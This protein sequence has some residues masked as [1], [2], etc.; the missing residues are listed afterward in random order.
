MNLRPSR[1]HAIIIVSLLAHALRLTHIPAFR[2]APIIRVRLAITFTSHDSVALPTAIGRI[3]RSRQIDI[4]MAA[5]DRL[6]GAVPPLC[7]HEILRARK[8][9]PGHAWFD[10][11]W[12]VIGSFMS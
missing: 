4:D 12:T 10:V 7:K 1:A 5:L 2:A 11:A 8:T 9:K 3:V 6:A